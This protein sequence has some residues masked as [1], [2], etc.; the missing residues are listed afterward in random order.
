[1]A[2][3][4]PS[5]Q[6]AETGGSL[7]LRPAQSTESSSQG[8]T[9]FNSKQVLIFQTFFVFPNS[10]FSFLFVVLVC[11]V[12]VFKTW[13]LSVFLAGLALALYN[14]LASHSREVCLPLPPEGWD[15][16][17]VFFFF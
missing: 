11:F 17:H 2:A 10:C 13:V 12:F 4:T 15:L 5:T 3:F 6:K 14:R 16:S 9:F 1:M 7:N 8:Y